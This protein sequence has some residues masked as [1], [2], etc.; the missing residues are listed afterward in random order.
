MNTLNLKIISW[1]KSHNGSCCPGK[2]SAA[3]S[4]VFPRISANSPAQLL[5]LQI[6]CGVHYAEASVNVASLKF[7]STERPPELLS[8]ASRPA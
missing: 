4:P 1:C 2:V 6:Y 8:E 7:A 5:A 3:H